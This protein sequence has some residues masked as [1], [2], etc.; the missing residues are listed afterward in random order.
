MTGPCQSHW[1]WWI[2]SRTSTGHMHLGDPCGCT[3]TPSE[4][5]CFAAAAVLRGVRFIKFNLSRKQRFD[6]DLSELLH[7]TCIA[8]K[9]M[10]RCAV[11]VLF[12]K[13]SS[14]L[15]HGIG[16]RQGLVQ[17]KVFHC[18][19]SIF[20][21]VLQIFPWIS[22]V[23]TFSA[24]QC[25]LAL[26]GQVQRWLR[27]Q[28]SG[29]CS[30]W[31]ILLYDIALSQLLEVAATSQQILL[32]HCDLFSLLLF[33]RNGRALLGICRRFNASGAD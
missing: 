1:L 10:R 33:W 19:N 4:L 32:S 29:K 27:G 17:H 30:L 23:C 3:Q 21:R 20:I 22:H 18:Q 31:N 13:I 5:S 11:F 26:E 2:A 25:K 9:N 15:K 7:I 14:T 16:G 8:R 24:I 28:R 6:V 12:W